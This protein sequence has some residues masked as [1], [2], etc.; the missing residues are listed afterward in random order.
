MVN[1]L[2]SLLVS[3]HFKELKK[4][5]LIIKYESSIKIINKLRKSVKTLEDD[6]SWYSERYILVIKELRLLQNKLN[7]YEDDERNAKK[8]LEHLKI[9]NE[10]RVKNGI[11]KI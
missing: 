3:M 4:S 2:N 8:F 7:K 5:E 11:G 9:V 6:I 10:N 1:N